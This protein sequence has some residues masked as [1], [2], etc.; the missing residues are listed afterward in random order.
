[1]VLGTLALCLVFGGDPDPD[2]NCFSVGLN[3]WDGTH[4]GVLHGDRNWRIVLLAGLHVNG[5]TPLLADHKRLCILARK[6]LN[7]GLL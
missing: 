2:A 4:G 1:V 5:A 3:F 7:V 6:P